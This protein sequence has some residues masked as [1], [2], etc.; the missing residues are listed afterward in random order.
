MPLGKKKPCAKGKKGKA[1][2]RKSRARRVAAPLGKRKS[3]QRKPATKP[4]A[5]SP[6]GRKAAGRKPREGRSAAAAKKRKVLRRKP[7]TK[8]G[9]QTPTRPRTTGRTSGRKKTAARPA[10]SRGYGKVREEAAARSR[11]V[12]LS[13]RD[14]APLP[15]V[16]NTRRKGR[17]RRD[18]RLFCEEYFPYVF[19][20]PWSPDHLKVIAKIERAVVHGGLFAMAMPRGDGKTSLAECACLFAL[21]YKHRRFVCLVGASELHA[22][23]MLDSI[24]TELEGNER[25]AD[26]FPEAIYPIQRLEGIANRCR[27]QLFEGERTHITWTAKEVV[28]PTIRRSAASGGILKVAGIT[29]RIRGMKFKRPDGEAVRP[30]LVI[31]DDPQ[32]DES[33]RSASQCANR[34]SILAGAV[35]GMAGPG[36]KIS[37]IMP[38]TVIRP[39]DMAD[40]ILDRDK[41]PGWNGERTKMVYAFPADEKLWRKYA[42]LRGDSLRMHGDLRDATA[43]YEAHRKAMDKGS[44]VAWAERFNHDE[45]S[46]IQHAMNLKFRDERAFFAEYQN[47]PLEE[48]S[49]G[50]SRLTVDQVI[51]KCSGY[52]RGEVPASAT[53]LTMFIDVHDKLLFYA[54]CAWE[55]RFS[56]HVVDYGAFPAQR[57]A[58]FTLLDAQGTLRRKYPG[59]GIDGAIHAGLEA[60]VSEYL[61]RDWKRGIGLVKIDRLLVD[62][63][64]KATVVADVRRKCGGAAMMLSKGVGIRASRKPILEYSRKPGATIGDHWYIPNVRKTGQFPHVLVDV[65]YWKS[66]LHEAFATAEG[67][68]GALMLFGKDG[69]QHDLLAEHIVRSETCVEVTGPG[70]TVREWSQWPSRPDNHWLDCLVGCMA[71]ASVQGLRLGEVEPVR[72]MPKRKRYTQADL[73][74]SG[75]RLGERRR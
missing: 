34:E 33:A 38:C 12:S 51:E 61:A 23:E 10:D 5:K 71:A 70:G 16:R 30:S 8:R 49:E 11:A 73:K 62:M 36:E 22:I 1:T 44:R 4:P 3:V 18:F 74:R 63:G 20:L 50:A 69:R 32:T 6:K 7:A 52:R 65:N 42:E 45:R 75:R 28:L 24:K 2:G 14:I 56:G 43:F 19:Y 48:T 15:R 29:G 41:H 64:Y 67:D 68:P 46:A 66:R 25:L 37:G 17:C 31:L 72:A 55:A 35:L 58:R 54:V 53:T 59:R 26:G 21:L 40:K 39:G 60:L 27:G 57:R 47:E 9:T 13:G